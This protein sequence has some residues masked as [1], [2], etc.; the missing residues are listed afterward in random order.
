MT[1]ATRAR[2]VPLCDL[3]AQYE[4]IRDE[5]RQAVDEVLESQAFIMGPQVGQ[6]EKQVADYCRCLHG[7]GCSSG[8]D[9]LLLALMALDIGPG[10]EVITTPFTFFAT[11][12]AIVRLR[13]KPVFVDIDRASYNLDTSQ[14][15]KAVSPRTKAILPVHLFGQMAEMGPILEIAR[16]HNLAVIE[17]AAQAIGAEYQGKRAGSLGDLGC[18]SFFPSKNLG[19]L[20]DG[21]MVVTNNPAL[22]EKIRVL[23]THGASKKYYHTLVGGNFRLDTIHA[24]AL[25]V[26]L[27]YLDQWTAARQRHAQYYREQIAASTPA[28]GYELPTELPDRRHVYNQFIIRS[29]K[30]DQLLEVFRQNKIGSAVYYPSPM[31]L[32]ECFRSLGYTQGDFPEAETAC[33]ETCALPMFPELTEEQQDAVVQVLAGA[34]TK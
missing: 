10:D 11:V 32:Q 23:R 29:R 26:K 33:R 13:A 16:R 20:G 19:G 6:L 31:H 7:V 27:G 4:T 15:G 5:I 1:V 30:R 22:A 24:A 3:R 12:G 17:D 28:D 18:L 25:I 8:S 2:A 9:A 21:G 14:I 34:G